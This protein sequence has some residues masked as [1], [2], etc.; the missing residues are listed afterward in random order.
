M[1]KVILVGSRG[2]AQA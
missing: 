1:S 2:S